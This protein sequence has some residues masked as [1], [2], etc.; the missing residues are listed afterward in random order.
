LNHVLIQFSG[1]TATLIGYDEYFLFAA[2]QSF[3]PAL[4]NTQVMLVNYTIIAESVSAF[5]T[6]I[7]ISTSFWTNQN[8]PASKDLP[9]WHVPFSIAW[10][11]EHASSLTVWDPA[12]GPSGAVLSTAAFMTP[13]TTIFTMNLL[14][15]AIIIPYATNSNATNTNGHVGGGTIAGIAIGCLIFIALLVFGSCLL[16][17]R[18][19]KKKSVPLLSA[20]IYNLRDFWAI[21]N[22][23]TPAQPASNRL[24]WKSR[25]T[26][27]WDSRT[28]GLYI[29]AI[30]TGIIL[31][32]NIL[33]LVLSPKKNLP[34]QG[35]DPGAYPVLPWDKEHTVIAQASCDH[36]Q[37]LDTW[38]HLIINILGVIL[39]SSIN[40]FLA[41]L[42]SPYRHHLDTAHNQGKWLDI[43]VP[44]WRNF[45]HLGLVRSGPW[46]VLL[47]LSLPITTV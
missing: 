40:G 10:E 32:L 1:Y 15:G 46:L 25:V 18:S 12:G 34:Y 29:L 24:G 43:G 5:T 47:L 11:Q 20:D 38:S 4:S 28:I 26:R 8:L 42:S 35:V 41:I 44:S 14:T 30:Q 19:R 2:C 23:M 22:G 33:L 9:L 37:S 45:R 13:S 27:L 16:F 6:P 3:A 39:L 17:K 31:V 36:I 21:S 7:F